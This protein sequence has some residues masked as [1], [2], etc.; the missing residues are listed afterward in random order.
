[1]RVNLVKFYCNHPKLMFPRKF[2]WVA[3]CS[4]LVLVGVYSCWHLKF[5]S[6]EMFRVGLGVKVSSRPSSA[7]VFF[8]MSIDFS[9]FPDLRLGVSPHSWAFWS[10]VKFYFIS[11]LAGFG[12][13]GS[14]MG[15]RTKSSFSDG[16]GV[17]LF[18]ATLISPFLSIPGNPGSPLALLVFA[19]LLI[20]FYG[21]PYLTEGECS[22]D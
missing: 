10:T 7:R 12:V 8:T 22:A 20:C 1:M 18:Y 15:F 11:I 5:R 14:F 19:M 6:R 3:G 21:V 2:A 9:S 4:L 16:E 17:C 13:K